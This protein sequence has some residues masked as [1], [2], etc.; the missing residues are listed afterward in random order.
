MSEVNTFTLSTSCSAILFPRGVSSLSLILFIRLSR[1]LS[2]VALLSIGYFLF[3]A[4]PLRVLTFSHASGQ[5]SSPWAS[6]VCPDDS[7]LGGGGLFGM[8]SHRGER[9]RELWPFRCEVF[10]WGS[11]RFPLGVSRGVTKWRVCWG[12]RGR[13]NRYLYPFLEPFF[14]DSFRISGE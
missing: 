11:Y 4:G 9:K 5:R 3:F 6:H 7:L 8:S 14:S 12:E 2:D 10:T 1:A 13:A